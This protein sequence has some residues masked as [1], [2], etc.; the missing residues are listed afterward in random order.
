MRER[1]HFERLGMLDSDDVGD[2]AAFERLLG[3]P[4][5]HCSGLVAGAWG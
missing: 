4:A 5:G 1:W 2:P 3:R